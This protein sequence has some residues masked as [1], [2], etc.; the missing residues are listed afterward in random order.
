MLTS[1]QRHILV[2]GC[3]KRG[4][5]SFPREEAAVARTGSHSD[6]ADDSPVMNEPA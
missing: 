5:E 3:G 1:P 4:E 6:E 2:K